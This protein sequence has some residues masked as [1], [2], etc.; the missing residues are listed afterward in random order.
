MMKL[1][2]TL[3]AALLILGACDNGSTSPGGGGNVAIRFGVAT[4]TANLQAN[5]Q[6]SGISSP[7]NDLT[8][9]G[10][11]GTLVIQDIK[12]VASRFKLKGNDQSTCADSV[13]NSHSNN[14]NGDEDREHDD[15][16]DEFRGGP[17]IVNIP[18]DG[19][20]VTITT[21]NVPAG[22]YNWFAFKVK[23][24]NPGDNADDDDASENANI[25]A[26]LTQMR[27]L[28]PNFPSNASMVVKGTFNGT[29]FTT[30]FRANMMVVQKLDP[31]LVVPGDNAVHVTIDPSLWFKNGSQVLD[32][33]A[34]N[35][36]TVQMGSGF[37][38]GVRG[39]NRHHD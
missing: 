20:M 15:D 33:A 25:P 1:R 2:F 13:A 9:T 22:T 26:L 37:L 30:Y 10:T 17:F 3:A 38:N 35:G 29:A 5:V 39:S 32:L 27:A 4:T 18:L 16:C 11:N 8:V 24:L 21:D 19:S 23:S 12:M 28:Y 7:A 31:P 6:A 14:G 36:Q 34:L